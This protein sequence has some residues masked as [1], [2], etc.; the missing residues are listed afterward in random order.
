MNE[1]SFHQPSDKFF[2]SFRIENSVGNLWFGVR[3]DGI[4]SKTFFKHGITKSVWKPVFRIEF[5]F[6]LWRDVNFDA[7]IA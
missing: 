5:L 3:F 1:L 6:S 7:I 2:S 4:S